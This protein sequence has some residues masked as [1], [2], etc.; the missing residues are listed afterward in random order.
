MTND[1]KKE[2]L[3]GISL[4]EDFEKEW[5][6]K[7]DKKLLIFTQAANGSLAYDEYS[8]VGV[9]SSG[10]YYFDRGI[11]MHLS[12]LQVLLEMEGQVH[13]ILV[14]SSSEEAISIFFF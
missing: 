13:E 4:W 7:E 6:D 3:V 10:S 12:E 11:Q 5:D 9:Y 1:P 8:I 14:L 2:V